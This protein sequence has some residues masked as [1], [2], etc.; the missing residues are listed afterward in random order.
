LGIWDAPKEA[1]TEIHEHGLEGKPEC[2]QAA[3]RR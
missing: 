2:D 3:A 1:D